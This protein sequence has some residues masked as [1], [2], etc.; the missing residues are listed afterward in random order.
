MAAKSKNSRKKATAKPFKALKWLLFSLGLLA[1][2]IFIGIF[3][4]KSAVIS[5]LKSDGFRDQLITGAEEKLHADI[6]LQ[7]FRWEGSTVY[8]D[9]WQAQ[10]HP[11]AFF[12]K[13]KVDGLRASLNGVENSALQIPEVRVNQ[14]SLVFSK[15]RQASKLPLA[16]SDGENHSS[17]PSVPKWLK[18]WIPKTAAVDLIRIDATNLSFLDEQGKQQLALTSVETSAQPMTASGT[19]EIK[20]RNGELLLRDFPPLSIRQIETRW[21]HNEIFINQASLGFYDTAEISGSGDITLASSPQLNL[22]L[23]ISNLNAKKLLSPEWEKKISGTLHAD[24][25]VKGNPKEQLISK[26]SFQL[27]DGALED[28]PLLDLIAQYTKM[29]RFKRL[30]LHKVSADFVKKGPQIKISNLVIQSDGLT[31]LEGSFILN[32]RQIDNGQFRLG[33][34]PG[35]LRWIPG[36]EQKVFTQAKDGFLWTDLTISGSLDQPKENLSSRL[37][38]AAIDTLIN[39][40]PNQALDAAKKALSN[41]VE[42]IDTGSKLLNSL[43]PLLK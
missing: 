10:G 40:A 42:T 25:T 5:Y 31:R 37:T 13:M 38:G 43:I 15:K 22:D 11:E 2:V 9:G 29:Q 26:G 24:F 17:N 36:A 28:L 18:K 39:D 19:W 1:V 23:Q 8:A 6:N 30:A 21:N 14:A 32:D 34:T 16:A 4:I 3:G 20:G 27:K 33:V 12:S 7:Q 35:T 41:P